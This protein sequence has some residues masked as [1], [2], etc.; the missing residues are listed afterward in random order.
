MKREVLN[1]DTVKELGE[2]A[3]SLFWILAGRLHIQ[4]CEWGEVCRPLAVVLCHGNKRVK[5][6]YENF[7]AASWEQAVGCVSRDGIVGFDSLGSNISLKS[8]EIAKVV[9]LK[10]GKENK[11]DSEGK[12]ASKNVDRKKEVNTAAAHPDSDLN[13]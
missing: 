4:D 5:A 8:E 7:Q 11:V 10:N 3:N 1:D 13:T 6:K 12:T 2:K 9:S